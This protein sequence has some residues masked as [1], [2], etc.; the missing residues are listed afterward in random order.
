VLT[1]AS[2]RRI[3]G[4][5]QRTQPSRFLDEIPPTLLERHASYYAPPTLARR[6]VPSGA[7]AARAGRRPDASD[8]VQE[9]AFRYED[10]DQSQTMG[11]RPGVR[12]RHPQF[13]VGTV[14]SVDGGGDDAKVVVRFASVGQKKLMAR[15]ARLE[16][17]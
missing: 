16:P 10:E 6:F 17:A 9:A 12:V 13:G 3:W 2:Q 4:T 11:L 8:R 15:F 5:Y 14:L 7:G 1:A